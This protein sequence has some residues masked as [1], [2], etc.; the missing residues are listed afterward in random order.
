MRGSEDSLPRTAERGRGLRRSSAH[1]RGQIPAT[2]PVRTEAWGEPPARRL[3]RPAGS[4]MLETAPF[5]GFSRLWTD[6]DR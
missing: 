4:S 1:P 3:A 2:M 5:S 6:A